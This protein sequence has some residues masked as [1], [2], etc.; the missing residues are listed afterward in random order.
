MRVLYA[1][2][3]DHKAV[4][5]FT[6]LKQ[7]VHIGI[8]LSGGDRDYTLMCVRICGAVEFFTRQ[9]PDLYSTRAAGVDNALHFLV[10]SLAGN[11]DVIEAPRT[12]FQRFADGMNAK[13]D[14]HRLSVYDNRHANPPATLAAGSG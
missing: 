4:L 6:L 12:R 9:E 5:R 10:M 8:L 2:E 7:E 3:N 1:V 14:D 13:D 11:A